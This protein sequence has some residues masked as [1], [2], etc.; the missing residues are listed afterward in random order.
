MPGA[1]KSIVCIAPC[2]K[3]VEIFKNLLYKYHMDKL[4]NASEKNRLGSQ[5]QILPVL[6]SMFNPTK[7]R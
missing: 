1:A 5:N 6:K 2:M 3:Q 4:K 7:P